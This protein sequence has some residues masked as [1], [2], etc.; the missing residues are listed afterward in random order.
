M[1]ATSFS[2]KEWQKYINNLSKVSNKA[3]NLIKNYIEKNPIDTQEDR[4][5]LI[6][7]CY[8]IGQK[9]GNAS[10]EYACQYYDAIAELEKRLLK[11]AEPANFASL[12]E[13]AKAVNGTAMYA[14]QSEMISSGVVR[15]IKRQTQ[16]TLLNNAIRD[17]AYYAWIPMGETCPFCLA[18][19]SN[20][21]QRASASILRGGHAEHIHANCDCSFAI[22]HIKETSYNFYKPE[23][24]KEIYDD[25][26]GRSSKAK[27]N[28]LRRQNYAENKEKI[29]EQKRSAYEKRK[30]LNSSKAEEMN[31]NDI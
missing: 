1:A 4:W 6:E 27:I 8:A 16:D 5:N 29:N 30:E 25:A 10:A 31:V 28:Y 21:W 7:Y 11:P 13:T 19:A 18:I 9:Y 23:K 3:K 15:L 22:K 20:G 24:Y 17:K 14:D 12:N 2:K 26:E